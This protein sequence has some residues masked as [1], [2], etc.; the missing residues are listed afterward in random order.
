MD[1]TFLHWGFHP[2][3]VYTMVGLALAFFAFNK[4]LP[5]SIRSVFYP[6]LGEK[7]HGAAGNF[8]DILTTWSVLAGT[9]YMERNLRSNHLAAPAGRFFT[10]AG[11]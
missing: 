7:I 8:I 2:W 6:V 11:G 4:G 10:G 1:L 9:R 3:A 5:L